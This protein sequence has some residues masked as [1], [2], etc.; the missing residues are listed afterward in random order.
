MRL[1]L[2]ISNRALQRYSLFP[3]FVF[4]L[5]KGQSRTNPPSPEQNISNGWNR[6]YLAVLVYSLSNLP[7]EPPQTTSARIRLCSRHLEGIEGS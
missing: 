7:L 4:H 1:F 2:A 5:Q 3:E 6:K